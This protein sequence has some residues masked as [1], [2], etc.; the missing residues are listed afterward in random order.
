MHLGTVTEAPACRACSSISAACLLAAP[1][2]I[3]QDVVLPPQGGNHQ[4]SMAECVYSSVAKGGLHSLC[5]ARACFQASHAFSS[6]SDDMLDQSAA[7]RL[8]GSLQY[9]QPPHLISSQIS[10][11]LLPMPGW[12]VTTNFVEASSS[13]TCCSRAQSIG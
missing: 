11:K 6:T 1:G 4:Q 5:L 9:T 13:C 10:Q 3:G 8:S 12:P 7:M 2:V